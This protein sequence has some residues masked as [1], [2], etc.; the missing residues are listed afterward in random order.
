MSHDP[1]ALDEIIVK[2]L[3]DFAPGS[4]VFLPITRAKDLESD[5]PA[6]S[7]LGIAK[8]VD[9]NGKSA[10][11][12]LLRRM[13]IGMSLYEAG[14]FIYDTGADDPTFGLDAAGIESVP[15]LH[16]L[17]G[18]GFFPLMGLGRKLGAALF[19]RNGPQIATHT[20][21]LSGVL[22]PKNWHITTSGISATT[23]PVQALNWRAVYRTASGGLI[24][25]HLVE[26]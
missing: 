18:A 23:G 4:L 5:E 26:R 1:P 11:I 14:S 2:R 3:R 8:T 16:M 7:G 25:A 9:L 20:P 21:D 15:T 24:A 12:F 6:K 17:P 10:A 22:G 19:T 13:Q